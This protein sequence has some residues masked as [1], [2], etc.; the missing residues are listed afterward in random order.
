ML[1]NTIL[2]SGT[3]G[4]AS[5]KE[6]IMKEINN[7]NKYMYGELEPNRFDISLKN[8]SHIIEN[9]KIK[10]DNLYADIKLLETDKGNIIKNIMVEMKVEDFSE[11]PFGVSARYIGSTD[12]C[13]GVVTIQKL[14]TYDIVPDTEEQRLKKKIE[15]RKRKIN[16]I[17]GEDYY[18][19]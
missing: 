6:D 4:L 8:V 10:N 13:S 18:E 19:H 11:I 1:I 9:A 3:N 17:L 2:E 5:F 7:T 14:L 12:P 16:K 15:S